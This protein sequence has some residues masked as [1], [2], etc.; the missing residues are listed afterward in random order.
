MKKMIV[1][2]F[3]FVF[4]LF[5]SSCSGIIDVEGDW[6][7]T[8]VQTHPEESGPGVLTITINQDKEDLEGVV[9]ILSVSTMDFTGSIDGDEITATCV[10][11]EDE[12]NITEIE[13]TVEGDTMTG[14]WENIS[15]VG[16]TFEVE[17]E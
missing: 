8:I 4:I 16:G 5:L 17:R 13:A 3:A 10:D 2:I 7:G 9:S 11:Q 6:S 14:T 1:L 12:N 15:G